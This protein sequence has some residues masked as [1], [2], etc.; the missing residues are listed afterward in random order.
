MSAPADPPAAGRDRSAHAPAV[1]FF[2]LLAC[3]FSFPLALNLDSHV[4]G[5][6]GDNFPFLWNFWWA[7]SALASHASLFDCPLLFAPLG[8][9]LVLH[10]H[11]ALEATVGATLLAPFPVVVAHNLV[12]LAGLSANGAATYALAYSQL[13]TRGPALLA[14]VIFATSSYI[15]LHL[16]GHFNLVHAWVLP[17][18]AMAWIRFVARP[19]FGS[20]ALTALAYAVA[21]YS[22]YYYFIYALL[23][24]P[25]W[26]I[27]ATWRFTC[28]DGGARARL[29]ARIVVAAMAIV[30]LAI[31]VI[32]VTGGGQFSIAGQRISAQGIRNPVTVLWLLFVVWVALRTRIVVERR[33]SSPLAS[34]AKN[35][36]WTAGLGAFFALPLIVAA[37]DTIAAGDYVSPAL[38]WRSAPGGVD[39]VAFVTGNPLHP[40]YG[41]LT[42]QVLGLLRVDTVDQVAWIGIVPLI[43]AA[44]TWRHRPGLPSAGPWALVAIAF[45]IWSAGPFLHVAGHGTGILLPQF[46]ARF[47]PLVSNARI[48]GR[49]FIV[50]VLAV[51]MLCA[52]VASHAR[53]SPRRIGILILVAFLDGLVAPFQLSPVPHGSEIERYLTQDQG[54]G[55]VLALPTG[56]QDGFGVLGNFDVHALPRQIEHGR[57]IVGGYISRVPE[58]IKQGYAER[59]VIA[60]FIALSTPPTSSGSIAL[61]A[62]LTAPL[63]ADGIRFVVVDRSAAPY[64]P[65]RIE[66]EERGLTLLLEERSRELY[67]VGQR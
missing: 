57:A 6:P 3:A 15:G 55:S 14:G 61:P 13:R 4:P 47:V 30:A 10:T 28:H 21:L 66:F 54:R 32:L 48:P 37:A 26:L 33:S 65:S 5:P 27:A 23:F 43:V 22:D 7:R 17:L 40:I 62:D 39:V 59:P 58:R 44:W 20:A 38:R 35:L 9:S 64:L 45:L 52:H 12:L 16:L 51:A 42:T 31:A 53:W 49:A 56:Y 41:S 29:I 24:A 8:T 46:F 19:G 50:V 67:L 2:V 34:V 1:V 60:S 36:A 11:T 18:A 25:I 63:A